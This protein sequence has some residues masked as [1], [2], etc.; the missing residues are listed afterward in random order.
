MTPRVLVDFTAV[1]ATASPPH[2][3][4]V[5]TSHQSTPATSRRPSTLHSNTLH[6]N[7]ALLAHTALAPRYSKSRRESVG[8]FSRLA[9]AALAGSS[10]RTSAAGRD[11]SSAAA[12]AAAAAVTGGPTPRRSHIVPGRRS[13]CGGSP[14]CGCC[15]GT[16]TGPSPR[17]SEARG[18]VATFDWDTRAS[19][20]TTATTA[21]TDSTMTDGGRWSVGG[22]VGPGEAEDDDCGV[23]DD[24]CCCVV[25][26][27]D[28]DTRQLTVRGGDARSVALVL[29]AAAALAR[30]D[31]EHT[32]GSG[33]KDDDGDN[34]P[35]LESLALL[36]TPLDDAAL[37][38][39]AAHARSL[40][41]L[42]LVGAW[43]AGPGEPPTAGGGLC[44]LR[45][46]RTLT[47]R[48]PAAAAA[49]NGALER[50]QKQQQ[51]QQQPLQ[52]PRSPPAPLLPLLQNNTALEA[53]SLHACA[54]AADGF[55][56]AL[57]RALQQQPSTSPQSTPSPPS[58][59][60]LGHLAR[61]YLTG[62]GVPGAVL[63]GLLRRAAGTLR[64]AFV[65]RAE[66]SV[67][68][69]ARAA[70]RFVEACDGGGG[71]LDGDG[72]DAGD[73]DAFADCVEVAIKSGR[74]WADAG[75]AGAAVGGGDAD[76][77]A[78]RWA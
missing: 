44:R 18:G 12:A 53:L 66:A 43:Y 33:Y 42:H 65:E 6:P 9:G 30:L 63:A 39:V 74:W 41:H 69:A 24:A 2:R 25:G 37:A 15:A 51:Q 67:G 29:R 5:R 8:E 75:V 7:S 22:Y 50:Q 23:G 68:E 71:G 77:G 52:Q 26:C 62:F 61:V 40:R 3:V 13:S 76:E 4:Y 54:G 16:T 47:L 45:A 73:P 38:A 78:V 59:L 19:T 55:A 31:T 49:G 1:A 72:G 11:S 10:A 32:G 46:L 17:P 60:P 35:G 64:V 48:P 28:E 36:W 70:G 21:L 14:R 20:A 57:E 27:L 58:P 34:A 56:D